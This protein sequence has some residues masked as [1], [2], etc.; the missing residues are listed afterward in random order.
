MPLPR[1]G[2][3]NRRG[4]RSG[5]L[6]R[7]DVA[8]QVPALALEAGELHRGGAGKNER[9]FFRLRPKRQGPIHLTGIADVDV[10][11][12]HD[13][14]LAELRGEAP[15]ADEVEGA[16]FAYVAVGKGVPKAIVRKAAPQR[17][18]IA[19][20]S[21]EKVG[22]RTIQSQYEGSTSSIGLSRH[23]PKATTGVPVLSNLN[24]QLSKSV[25]LIT[26]K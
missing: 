14:E 13:G 19:F 22:S 10:V 9:V 8:E 25:C 24:L 4:D 17:A 3:R 5:A 23:L 11:V 16:G 7:H 2:E 26:R 15:G 6:V 12:H 20:I 1:K 18:A 21:A